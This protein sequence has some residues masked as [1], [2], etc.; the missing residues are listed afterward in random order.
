MM[1]GAWLVG[2]FSAIGDC[3]AEVAGV[4]ASIDA[5]VPVLWTLWTLR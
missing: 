3:V 5:D 1:I 4:E 2:N